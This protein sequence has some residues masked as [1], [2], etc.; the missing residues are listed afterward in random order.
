MPDFTRFEDE[1]T[2]LTVLDDA[3]LSVRALRVLLDQLG[4]AVGL[5][6]AG[7]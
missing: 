6:E 2:V 7:Q 4:E 5:V 3:E 1:V